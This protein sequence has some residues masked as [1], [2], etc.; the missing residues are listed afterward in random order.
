MMLDLPFYLFS[1]LTL[2]EHIYVDDSKS[3]EHFRYYVKLVEGIGHI[4]QHA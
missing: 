3:M 4:Q 2:K 1:M